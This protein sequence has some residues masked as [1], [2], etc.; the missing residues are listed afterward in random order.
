[1]TAMGGRLETL[2]ART[3]FNSVVNKKIDLP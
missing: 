1:M 2:E 3:S